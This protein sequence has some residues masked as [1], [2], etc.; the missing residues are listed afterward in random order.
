MKAYIPLPRT[1]EPDNTTF[2]LETIEHYVVTQ[3]ELL[4]LDQNAAHFFIP[5]KKDG[6]SCPPEETTV[7]LVGYNDVLGRIPVYGTKIDCE[8][9][10][11]ALN[12]LV[13]EKA[14]ATIQ[15]LSTL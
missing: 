13:K 7:Y 14:L 3:I 15:K 5:I 9:A 4:E 1:I 11:K 10:C 8:S 12:K 2:L 6:V